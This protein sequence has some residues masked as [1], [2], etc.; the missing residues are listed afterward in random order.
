MKT[1]VASRIVRSPWTKQHTE[2]AADGRGSM[3]FGRLVDDRAKT[4]ENEGW[5]G[6]NFSWFGQR[7]ADENTER[8]STVRL[9]TY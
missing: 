7:A 9:A 6:R 1:T 5:G 4:Q 3:W 8:F 2:S